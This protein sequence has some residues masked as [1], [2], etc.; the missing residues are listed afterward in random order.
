VA[1]VVGDEIVIRHKVFLS[2]GID[3]RLVDAL[4]GQF[5]ERIRHYLEN[6]ETWILF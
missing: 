6:F 5:L 4:G 1:A 3:H 2:V